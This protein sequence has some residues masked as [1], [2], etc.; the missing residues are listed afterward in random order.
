MIRAPPYK[1]ILEIRREYLYKDIEKYGQKKVSDIDRFCS[2][3][4]FNF[5]HGAV[6]R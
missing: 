1:P 3:F 4:T 6:L 5:F 2:R